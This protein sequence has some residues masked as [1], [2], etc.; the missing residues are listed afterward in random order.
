MKL[1]RSLACALLCAPILVHAQ[2]ISGTVQTSTNVLVSGATV[3]ATAG[4]TSYTATTTA[5]GTFTMT[6]PAGTYTVDVEPPGGSTF[7]PTRLESR[8][9][10]APLN[11][12]TL[13]LQ[14]GFTVSG[15]VLYQGGLPVANG[16]TDIIDA[17]TGQKLFTP[18]DNTSATGTFSMV[19]PAGT[20]KVVADPAA[21]S[22]LSVESAAFTVAG[23]VTVPTITLPRVMRSPRP[24]SMRRPL[25]D[26]PTSTSTS[27]IRSPVFVCKPRR[28]RP[29]RT[30]ASRSSF[31]PALGASISTHRR[32]M[33]TWVNNSTAWRSSE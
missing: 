9:V 10:I 30:A 25:P 21:G 22:Y 26:S 13:T 2:S 8:H 16:D 15:T 7:A 28:T 14:P 19:V 29:P 6:V 17:A 3:T 24:S 1:I 4:T 5:T 23:N 31:R 33:R 32:V 18:N 20:Y 11:V 12:G 27:K